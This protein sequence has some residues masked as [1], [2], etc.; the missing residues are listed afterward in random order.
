MLQEISFDNVYK[1]NE[2]DLATM[3]LLNY[4]FIAKFTNGYPV[5]PLINFSFRYCGAKL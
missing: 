1:E 3:L 5:A 4:Q 2:L